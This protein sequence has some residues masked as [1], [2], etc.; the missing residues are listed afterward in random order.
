MGDIPVFAP[1]RKYACWLILVL[2]VYMTLEPLTVEE[3][4]SPFHEFYLYK[5]IGCLP[6]M[7]AGIFL[8]RE[9]VHM[10]N[11]SKNTLLVLA[12]FYVILVLFNGDADI[13]AYRFGQSYVI[14]YM[15][16]LVASILLFNLSKRLETNKLVET[17]SKGTLLIMGLHGIIIEVS[18]KLCNFLN[19]PCQSFIASI[20]VMVVCYF[21]I[22]FLMKKC[23]ILLGK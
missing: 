19:L 15:C 9:K 11:I 12:I 3:Y 7:I 23:P 18:W 1:V 2:I 10:I 16:A 4:T 8:K 22:R 20:V 5:V 14:F 17:Y 13:F 6:F 21:P